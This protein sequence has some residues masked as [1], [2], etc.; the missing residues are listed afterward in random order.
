VK[1]HLI[2]DRWQ[3][4]YENKFYVIC[5]SGNANKNQYTSIRIAKTETLTILNIGR[6]SSNRNYYSLLVRAQNGRI[7]LEDRLAVS[8]KGEQSYHTPAPRCLPKSLYPCQPE[9]Q[10]YSS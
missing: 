4:A 8:Y 5:D 1:R 2:K 3:I 6:M 7:A 9:H 10:Y